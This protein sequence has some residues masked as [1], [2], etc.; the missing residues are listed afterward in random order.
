MSIPDPEEREKEELV[1]ELQAIYEKMDDK[2]KAW[3]SRVVDDVILIR[4]ANVIDE[5]QCQLP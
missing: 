2:D 4:D 1:D 3:L 5:A